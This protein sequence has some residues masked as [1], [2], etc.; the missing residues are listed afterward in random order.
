MIQEATPALYRYHAAWDEF[1]R[2]Q[3]DQVRMATEQAKRQEATAQR[4]LLLS[5]L[6]V[7]GRAGVIAIFATR[8]VARVVASRMRV[9]EKLF[10]L[11]SELEQRVAQRTQELAHADD[12]LRGSLN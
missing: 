6:I 3:S 5:I 1:L 4:I 10:E 7:G 11:N 8:R 2:F 9:Q 12:Q